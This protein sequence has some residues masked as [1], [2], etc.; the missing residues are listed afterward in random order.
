M[1]RAPRTGSRRLS[2]RPSMLARRHA[3]PALERALE[4]ARPRV[5]ER[6]GDLAVA[7]ARRERS[8]RDVL[9]DVADESAVRH[10]GAPQPPLQ[11]PRAD[12]QVVREARQR[13]IARV[14]AV[15]EDALDG[16]DERRRP[17]C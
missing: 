8:V 4:R 10:P 6:T 16:I 2:A 7:G 15:L 17:M 3:R 14:K 12:A 11:R 13:E 5:A 9:P 1:P